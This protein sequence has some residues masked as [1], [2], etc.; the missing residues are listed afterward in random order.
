MPMRLTAFGWSALLAVLYGL[1]LIASTF[2]SK[3][4]ISGFTF[5]VPCIKLSHT[6]FIS[7]VRTALP[8]T[9]PMSSRARQDSLQPQNSVQTPAVRDKA[10]IKG[11]T[12]DVH[13]TASPEGGSRLR[14]SS[15]PCIPEFFA[16]H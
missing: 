6:I 4:P 10:D 7:S 13:G 11:C 3:E 8:N 2:Q 1:F 14:H 15:K 9:Q 5:F 12:D 16:I